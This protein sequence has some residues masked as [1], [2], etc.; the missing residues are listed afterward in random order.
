MTLAH[1][2]SLVIAISIFLTVFA[3]GLNAS[4]DDALWLFHKPGLLARSIFSM[5]VLMVVFAIIVAKLFHLNLVIQTAI[6]ALAISPVPPIFPKKQRKVGATDSYAVALVV[7]AALASV[8]LIPAWLGFLDSVFSFEANL[9]L[10]KILTIVFLK[11][12]LPLFAGILVHHFA[13]HFAGRAA[14]PISLI[15]MVLLVIGVLPV[16]FTSYRAMWEMVGNGVLVDVALFA[17]VGIA[18]GHLLGG[19]NPDDRSVLALATSARHPGLASHNCRTKFSRTQ[20]CGHDR[21]AV[22]PDCGGDRRHTVHQM[23][24]EDAFLS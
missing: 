2:I 5:N 9:A 8:V 24:K 1:L 4:L 19:P 7:S 10:G 12:L 22:S 14:K 21:R 13:P 16:L 11:I 15:A 18:A 6:I 23:E 20:R 17:V 3:L